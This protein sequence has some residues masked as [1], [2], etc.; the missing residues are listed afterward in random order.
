MIALAKAQ[1][2]TLS[3]GTFSFVL[4]Q[5]MEKLKKQESIDIVR[6]PFRSG[7][8]V[9]NAICPAP[10]RSRSSG[11]PTCCRRSGPITSP[12]SR[13]TR[14]IS[15]NSG[16]RWYVGQASHRGVESSPSAGRS[17]VASG[18]S[19][20]V[21]CWLR[22][23]NRGIAH[24]LAGADLRSR[25]AADR[26]KIGSPGRH[27]ALIANIEISSSV[28]PRMRRRL[29][30]ASSAVSATRSSLFAW[31]TS[32]SATWESRSEPALL[33]SSL[34]FWDADLFSNRRAVGDADRRAG[35]DPRVPHRALHRRED[36]D[37]R[38]SVDAGAPALRGTRDTAHR[39][40]GRQR[41]G[42]PAAVLHR[43]DRHGAGAERLPRR[44][45]A[46]Q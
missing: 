1:P 33:S 2:S 3:Y 20:S 23:R 7:D 27:T 12:A 46:H 41:A 34:R 8:E 45:G 18:S 22:A 6:V 43:S 24:I 28:L 35:G 5:Y 14:G 4:V 16:E 37:Q 29:R 31:A 36:L 44:A 19:H 42:R 32:A 21:A 17:G 40:A 13:S 30:A 10:R 15:G 38:G 26:R 39:Q 9:V 11:S 25:P